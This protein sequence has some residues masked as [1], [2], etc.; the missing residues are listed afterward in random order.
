MKCILA[1]FAVA[2]LAACVNGAVRFK[3]KTVLVTGG[4][5]GIGYQTALQFA[6]EG[7]AVIICGRDVNKEHYSGEKAAKA[8]N[9]DTLVSANHGSA[10]F[11]KAD[12]SK[13]EDVDNLFA[14]IM[15]KEGTLDIAINNAGISGPVGKLGD[16]DKYTLGE[17]DPILNNFY[18]TMRCI[19]KEEEIMVGQNIN[20]SIVN[21]AAVDGYTAN[22]NL[23]LFSASKYAIIGLS[24]S[25]ALKHLTGED[26]PY[27]RVN[28]V[29]PTTTATPH[30]FNLVKKD[31]QP[32]E[33]DW[34]T[35]D[36]KEWKEALPKIVE[37][38]PMGRIG[39]PNE[40]ANTILW[41]CTDDAEFISGDIIGVD[42]GYWAM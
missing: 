10:R 40:V 33:G 42:G 6:Q 20:G 29:A 35:E 1:V 4:T 8:I 39:R 23:P 32:W 16:T 2:V 15:K 9:D 3:G 7:A 26:G 11:V 5:S 25:L 34:V 21:V 17:H 36:S 31:K 22:S 28:S 13:A 14:D 41:L 37:H 38:I 30:A 27:I 18:G 12:V 24:H 19:A